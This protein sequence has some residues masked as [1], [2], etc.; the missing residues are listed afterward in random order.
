MSLQLHIPTPCT[1]NWDAMTPEEQG[2][3]CGHCQK[4]VIDFSQMT[5]A[6]LLNWFDK[7]SGKAVCGR[8]QPKQL[9]R[10]LHYTKPYKS[11]SYRKAIA[12]VSSIAAAT[13]LAAQQ[14]NFPLMLTASSSQRYD[15]FVEKNVE[16]SQKDTIKEQDSIIIR[17]KVLFSKDAADVVM[18]AEV[19][20]MHDSVILATTLTNENG[21][22]LNIPRDIESITLIVAKNEYSSYTRHINLTDKKDIIQIDNI[23]LLIKFPTRD[24][25]G[26]SSTLGLVSVESVKRV[27]FYFIKRP[28]YK[29][30]HFF[31]N[32]F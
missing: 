23:V 25:N 13:H 3:F 15:S 16:K 2:R 9:E 27:R 10:T 4:T 29:V 7:N 18:R 32:L 1:E 11:I 5:D 24:L 6:E 26:V 19:T 17:G 30:R 22:S 28:Y 14:N 12:F 21:F 31:R 20:A 8:F